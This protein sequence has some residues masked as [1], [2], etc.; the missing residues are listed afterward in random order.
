MN[1]QALRP[2][3][4][5]KATLLF[6]SSLTV[7][8]GAIVAPALPALDAFFGGGEANGLLVRLTLTLPALFIVLASPIAGHLADRIGRRPTLI[9]AALIYAIGGTAGALC[10]HII[11]LL[12]SRAVLGI[13]VGGLMTAASASITDHYEEGP[14]RNRFMGLQSAAMIGGG[15]IFFLAGG[16]LANFS[17]RIPFYLYLSALLVIPGVLLSVRDFG[18]REAHAQTHTR[19]RL[20]TP[21]LI[22]ALAISFFGMIAYYVIPVQLPFFLSRKG[23]TPFIVGASIALVN[24]ASGIIS[25]QYFRFRRFLTN[26]QVA[27]LGFFAMGI[28]F[29]LLSLST[30]LWQVMGALLICGIGTGLWIPNVT[31]WIASITPR[32]FQGRALGL[33]VTS[34]FL[35]QFIS[36]FAT[37]PLLDGWGLSATFLGSGALLL[38][39]G[40]LLFLPSILSVMVRKTWEVGDE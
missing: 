24:L 1:G 39:G 22:L 10:N 8:A 3:V 19:R 16:L 9:A 5:T 20:L 31:V 23:A 35:G 12:I 15:V 30:Q 34:L 38:T 13:G 29:L 40:A 25:S 36:P 6:A 17:W 7:M 28:A 18:E 33:M 26:T 21:P 2:T 11:P 4:L 14:S 27:A 32:Q 37:Q